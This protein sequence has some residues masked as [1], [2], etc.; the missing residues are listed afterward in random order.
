[1]SSWPAKEVSLICRGLSESSKLPLNDSTEV[2]NLHG[3]DFTVISTQLSNLLYLREL[4]LSSNRIS[5]MKALSNLRML[6]ILNLSCNFIRKVEGM[7]SLSSLLFLNLSHNQIEDVSGFKEVSGSEYSLSVVSLHDNKIANLSHLVTSLRDCSNIR[8]LTLEQDDLTNP[9]C[10][11]IDYRQRLLSRLTQILVLD[12]VSRSGEILRL[13]DIPGIALRNPGSSLD[14]PVSVDS[15]SY[16][17]FK[18]Q[19]GRFHSKTPGSSMDSQ[20]LCEIKTPQIDLVME[21]YKYKYYSDNGSDSVLG[22]ENN[23]RNSENDEFNGPLRMSSLSMEST[24]GESLIIEPHNNSNNSNALRKSNGTSEILPKTKER[25]N[26]IAKPTKISTKPV[27][28]PL[29]TSIKSKNPSE[30]Q[31][32]P[33]L[34]SS[35]QVDSRVGCK[36]AGVKV[37]NEVQQSDKEY[38]DVIETTYKHLIEELAEE[39]SRSWKAEQALKEMTASVN[40]AKASSQE[41]KTQYERLIQENNHLKECFNKEK[42]HSINLE[43]KISSMDQKLEDLQQRLNTAKENMESQKALL[44]EVQS[45]AVEREN[46]HM[47]ILNEE[48]KRFEKERQLSAVATKQSGDLKSSVT[49]LQKQVTELQQLLA[50]RELEHKDELRDRFKLGSK[51]LRSVIER[52]LK[53]VK[54]QYEDRM[55]LQAERTEMMEK[56]YKNVEKELNDALQLESGQVNQLEL[57]CDSI[58]KE[59]ELNKQALIAAQMKDKKK[60]ETLSQLTNVVKKQ[61]DQISDLLKSEQEMTS[62]HKQ[63]ME[64]ANQHLAE[65]QKRATQSDKLKHDCLTY[66]AQIEA[67]ESLIVGLRAE[68]KVWENELAQQG[69]SLAQDRGRLEVKL[70]SLEVEIE[71]LKKQLKSEVDTVKIKMKIIDDQAESIRSLKAELHQKDELIKDIRE[72]AYKAQKKIEDELLL[73]QEARQESQFTIEKLEDRKAELKDQL[74]EVVKELERSQNAHYL[75]KKHWKDKSDLISTLEA[76]VKQAKSIWENKEKS[77][78]EAC[79]KAKSELKKNEEKMSK[80]DSLF[81]Q[82]LDD[83]E[84]AHQKAL[85]QLAKDQQLELDNAHRKILDLE[86]EMR[87]I[88]K[89]SNS[90]Q[91]KMSKLAIFFGNMAP[92]INR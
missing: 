25:S 63:Q 21:K 80:M 77:L 26:K 5:S 60:S 70:E 44:S 84:S 31:S 71:C 29:K 49:S 23:L 6:R 18:S 15:S 68:R 89:E 14:F 78:L 86:D 2:V 72:D 92:E 7:V 73:E 45:S 12:N 43:Q 58:V 61:K 11:Q 4:D 9:V 65:M 85:S 90:V 75:L 24:R 69:T 33:N 28:K 39:R 59:N 41:I 17:T 42:T 16:E 48:R 36:K 20:S 1:M 38:R 40:H 51:E 37:D 30:N 52:E 54:L 81:R 83:K 87:E 67:Q 74:A 19:S 88:L 66:Q 82:Q 34:C 55:K 56:H 79:E 62:K 91:A 53:H 13:G 3:N 64:D 76:Q 22:T 35:K 47:R 10:S 46:Q 8:C 50:S 27:Q 32:K 57:A